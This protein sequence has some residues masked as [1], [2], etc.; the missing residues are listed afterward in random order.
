MPDRRKS[1]RVNKGKEFSLTRRRYQKG[2]LVKK[3]KNWVLRYR[4]D[5]LNTDGTIGRIHRS[6][7][8][9]A[10]RSKREAQR[11]ADACL[12]KIND[13]A[14][15][16]QATITLTDF[17][18]TYF[19]PEILP[20][21][22]Y[23]TQKLNRILAAKHLLPTLG[24]HKLCD[25][26]RMHIQQFIGQKQR[27]KYAPQTLAHFRNL[28]SK[29]FSTAMNWG[30]MEFS[31]AQNIGLPPME[32][33]RSARV[34]SPEEISKLAGTLAEPV[35]TIF[36][37]GT[38]TGLRVGEILALKVQ[39]V[40]TTHALVCVRRDVYCGPVGIPKTPGSERQIPLASPLIPVL[41]RWLSMRPA[42]SDW[43]FPSAAGIPLRDRNL[44]R[45][46][47]WP[48]CARLRI[49]RF[50]WHSLRHTFSTF[51]GNAGVAVPILQS[52]LGHA[53]PETTMVYTHPLED[54][55]RQAVEDLAR[56]LFPNVPSE[57]KLVEKGSNLIQ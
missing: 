27:E 8:L 32:R 53:S 29:L 49:P 18:D 43:L 10:L 44:L 50:S 57:Q 11:A 36:L 35:R 46:H 13:G 40:D 22:K 45:R 23:S 52:L 30:W 9:G 54:V 24:N 4:E 26:S 41:S 37:L 31:P 17:W 16:P 6:L 1:G 15:Q 34:L 48:A 38:L 5:I 39:D 47:L 21:L 42:R 25:L 20:T 28:L 56:L 33:T 7:V 19:E 14:R 55:K 51:N 2:C 3:G 12:R